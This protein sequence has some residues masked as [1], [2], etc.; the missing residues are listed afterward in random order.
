MKIDS[1]K[2]EILFTVVEI[3]CRNAH[4]NMEELHAKMVNQI[5]NTI[6]A[7]R[8]H[9]EMAVDGYD[10]LDRELKVLEL[11]SFLEFY[12]RRAMRYGQLDPL[13]AH[14][15]LEFLSKLAD[16]YT[17]RFKQLGVVFDFTQMER[18]K[19]DFY[20]DAV[21]YTMGEPVIGEI[22]NTEGSL[23]TQALEAMDKEFVN[24]FEP[25]YSPVN[26]H[27]DDAILL[28]QNQN[29]EESEQNDECEIVIP[30]KTTV[31]SD[32]E[33]QP[34]SEHTA[35]SSNEQNEQPSVSFTPVEQSHVWQSQSGNGSAG[36][37]TIEMYR[38]K[39]RIRIIKSQIAM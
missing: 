8:S 6:F 16:G 36:D 2:K 9:F 31:T 37:V 19:K 11:K 10:R 26:V 15:Y 35:V 32:V 20:G 21:I 18:Q 24:Y 5:E 12:I 13:Y 4:Y 14:E 23:D 33:T 30:K 17:I 3:K 22:L 28:Q 39:F 7:L 25:T 29:T 1:A 38:K 34:S 27:V